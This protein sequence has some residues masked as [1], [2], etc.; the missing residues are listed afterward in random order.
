MG[1][2]ERHYITAEASQLSMSVLSVDSESCRLVYSVLDVICLLFRDNTTP[3]GVV[4][5]APIS[6]TITFGIEEGLCVLG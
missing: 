6:Y 3:G 1:A 2:S 5:Y 4:Q